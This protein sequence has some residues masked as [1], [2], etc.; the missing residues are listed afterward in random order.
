MKK[1]FLLPLILCA[2]L[3]VGEAFLLAIPVSAND[4]TVN[5]ADGSSHTCSGYTCIA[6]SG[7][8]CV[9]Y[10]AGGRQ[11]ERFNCPQ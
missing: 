5:C 8:Y 11:L 9:A 7:N 10:N 2:G 1:L 6:Y 3:F 4:C